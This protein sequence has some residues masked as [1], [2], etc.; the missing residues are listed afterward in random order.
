MWTTESV[1]RLQKPLIWLVTLGIGLVVGRSATGQEATFEQL[2]LRVEN[3]G[4][5]LNE[6]EEAAN[7]RQQAA[8]A[9]A[10][11]SAAG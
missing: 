5:A 3:A 10:R 8:T 7:A 4:R 6:L 9:S 11:E 2:S 1:A